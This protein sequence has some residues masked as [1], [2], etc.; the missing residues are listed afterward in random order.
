MGEPAQQPAAGLPEE[1]TARVMPFRSGPPPELLLGEAAP[2]T[3]MQ[4]AAERLGSALGSV[5]SRLREARAQA[6]GKA[7]QLREHTAETARKNLWQARTQAMQFANEQPEYVIAAAAGLA[8]AMGFTLRLWR[9]NHA[10][11]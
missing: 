5:A 10:R 6:P 11:R 7:A 8:F 1:Y 3:S 2:K 9:S 4:L